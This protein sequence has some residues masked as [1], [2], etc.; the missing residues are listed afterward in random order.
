MYHGTR[1]DPRH[2]FSPYYYPT[3]LSMAAP[4]DVRAALAAQSSAWTAA[5][6]HA[7]E[8]YG[9]RSLHARALGLMARAH[10]W[11]VRYAP[12]AAR[13]AWMP[14]VACLLAL[15]W[16]F[17]EEL[18]VALMLCTW[19]FV[20][21]NKVRARRKHTSCAQAL[22]GK[23]CPEATLQTCMLATGRKG[24]RVFVCCAP[25]RAFQDST[26]CSMVEGG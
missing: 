25:S 16:R 24:A 15:S 14:Q 7:A 10:P 26:N 18:P 9:S 23:T 6:R 4:D 20:T 11:M 13:A 12:D 19:A 3:Y 8:Q 2:S 1:Q 21:F 5:V 22:E 17:H